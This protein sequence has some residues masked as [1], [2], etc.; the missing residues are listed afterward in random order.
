MRIVMNMASDRALAQLACTPANPDYLGYQDGWDTFA[1][2]LRA[3]LAREGYLPNSGLDR[4]NPPDAAE[5]MPNR[6]E[7]ANDEW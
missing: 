2:L 1:K 7:G 5:T 6:A 3:R 4:N